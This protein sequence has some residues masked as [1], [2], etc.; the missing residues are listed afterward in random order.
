MLGLPRM[1]R[2]GVG[3]ASSN[4]GFTLTDFSIRPTCKVLVSVLPGEGHLVSQQYD[5]ALIVCDD[6]L[7]YSRG[8]IAHWNDDAPLVLIEHDIEWSDAQITEV[9]ACNYSL[10]S[11]AYPLHWA[12]T[13][14]VVDEFAHKNDGMPVAYGTEWAQWSA[15]GFCKIARSA[16]TGPFAEC[17]WRRVE[18]AVNATVVGPWHLHWPPAKHHHWE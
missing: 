18:D 13:G 17:H 3:R 14:H 10:C 6:D 12:N 11:I 9:I 15:I 1:V 16:R 8:I 7:A 5:V 4:S 2:T